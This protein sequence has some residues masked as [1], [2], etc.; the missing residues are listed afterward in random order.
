MTVYRYVWAP[1]LERLKKEFD[2][3]TLISGGALAE[4]CS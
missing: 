1:H 2:T 3:H 4:H